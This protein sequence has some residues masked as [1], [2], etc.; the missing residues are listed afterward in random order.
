MRWRSPLILITATLCACSPGAEDEEMAQQAATEQAAADTMA[1][2]MA[3]YDPSA[4]DTISWDDPAA[5][6]ERGATVFRF[7]CQKCHG[8][9]G[10]GDARFVMNGDTLR[11]P[12]FHAEDWPYADDRDALREQVYIGS[13]DGMPQGGVGGLG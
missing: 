10:Y 5:A 8:P 2:A 9:N 12:S 6:V 11:P 13:L 4:F 3:A 1:M 7:S